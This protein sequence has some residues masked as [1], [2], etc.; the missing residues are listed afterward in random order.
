M[1]WGLKRYHGTRDLHFITFSC[2]RRQ[3]LL[4]SPRA[5]R[6]FELVLEQV[7]R[8]YKF[9]ITGYVV[10][11]EHVHLL[12]SEPEKGTLASALQV[13]KQ[14]VAQR[15][16]GGNQFWQPRYYDFNVSSQLK[17]KEKLR[18]LHRN[19]VKRGLVAKP[20]DWEWSSFRHW[21]TGET[22]VVEIESQWTARRQAHPLPPPPGARY[23][24]GFG[25]CGP[26]TSCSDFVNFPPALFTPGN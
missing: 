17:C 14:L 7:R 9:F 6:T 15:L 1:P 16:G 5:K 8:Q 21:L 13:L 11:P 26:I 12:M 18:Y 19:P 4:N 10:M 25:R 24:P 22:G 23:L 2:Y 3:P 20:E